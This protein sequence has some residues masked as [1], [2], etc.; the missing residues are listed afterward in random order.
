MRVAR[1][2]VAGNDLD[3]FDQLLGEAVRA[4]ARDRDD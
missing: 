2:A 4:A 3:L 1:D